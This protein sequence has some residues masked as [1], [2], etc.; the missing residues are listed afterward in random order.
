MSTAEMTETQ[1][2]LAFMLDDGLFAIRVDKIREILDFSTVT[3]VPQMPPYVRGIINL[4][5][6]VVPV[7]DMRVKF[8]M[9]QADD[10]VDTCI[11]VVEVLVDGKAT[12]TITIG[13]LADSVQE[14]FELKAGQIEP[15]PNIGAKLKADFILG[16]GKRDDDFIIILDVDKTFSSVELSAAQQVSANSSRSES[17]TPAEKA[18]S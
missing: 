8:G 13:V 15:P 7:I 5:G 12:T 1:Q 10:T 18:T 3:R 11:V 16:L 17:E 14:V 9:P 6:S 2:Y 4:R